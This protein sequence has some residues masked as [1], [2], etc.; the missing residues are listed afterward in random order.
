MNKNSYFFFVVITIIIII[1]I[2]IIFS[3]NSLY[4]LKLHIYSL[5][6]FQQITITTNINKYCTINQYFN[7]YSIIYN[8]TNSDNPNY[9]NSSSLKIAIISA[10]FNN[11]NKYYSKYIF[12][13]HLSYVIKHKL[14]YIKI[15]KIFNKN[16]GFTKLNELNDNTLKYKG[17]KPYIFK[18]ILSDFD[19]YFDYLFWI[20]FDAIF[21]NCSISIDRD[22]INY[23]YDNNNNNNK[24]LIFGRDWEG[25]INSGVLIIKN[26]NWIKNYFLNNSIYII[27]NI[28]NKQYNFIYNFKNI[29]KWAD[30]SIFISLLTGFNPYKHNHNK[31]GKYLQKS[32]FIKKNSKNWYSL[33]NIMFNQSYTNIYIKNNFL[34]KNIR[35]HCVILPQFKINLEAR[36]WFKYTQIY[37]KKFKYKPFI[38]HFAGTP[39]K[40]FMKINPFRNIQSCV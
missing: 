17:Q 4:I 5:L 24:D 7:N 36:A 28:H 29:C 23:N 14:I 30:Q 8:C 2:T 31:Y 3:W 15:N 1:G 10:N 19:N 21:Y 38:I 16:N 32:F 11:N 26:S 37:K 12:S 20:D 25:I 6:N 35:N 18:Q 13:N 9:T 22:I 33:Y 40:Q 34:N 27:D 39:Y